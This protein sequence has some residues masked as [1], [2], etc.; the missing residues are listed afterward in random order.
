MENLLQKSYFFNE[1]IYILTSKALPY[2]RHTW[3]TST[4]YAKLLPDKI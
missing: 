3:S 1:K 4:S 2:K